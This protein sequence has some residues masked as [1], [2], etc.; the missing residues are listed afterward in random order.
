MR[1]DHARGSDVLHF[2]FIALQR[3]TGSWEADDLPVVV[4]GNWGRMAVPGWEGRIRRMSA[5]AGWG[6]T[7]CGAV[8]QDW[9]M[10]G[11]PNSG[12]KSTRHK[13]GGM[14]IINSAD[15][16]AQMSPTHLKRNRE[17]GREGFSM[18]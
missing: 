2:S 17:G 6:C 9:D 11:G 1:G 7:G 8:A 3:A 5:C 14:A 15:L 13:T 16:L 4:G 18:I 12:R 10:S